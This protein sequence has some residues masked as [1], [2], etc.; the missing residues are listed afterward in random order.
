MATNVCTTR[1]RG[2][3]LIEVMIVVVIISILAMVALPS[4]QDS[5]RKSRRADCKDRMFAIA[6]AQERHFTQYARYASALSGA[7]SSANLGWNAGDLTSEGGACSVA[8]GGLG[9]NNTQYTLT[10]TPNNAD[11]EC[12]NLTL[13]SLGVKGVV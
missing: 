11:P 4:Y 13:N 12:G 3:S 5:V 10:A 2:F 6:Q 1:L 8:V 7:E 9:A